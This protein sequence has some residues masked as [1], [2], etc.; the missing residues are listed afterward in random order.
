MDLS[1]LLRHAK[2]FSI[3]TWH[4]KKGFDGKRH[5]SGVVKLELV[6]NLGIC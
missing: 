5:I 2:L 1:L 3:V 6:G 4:I